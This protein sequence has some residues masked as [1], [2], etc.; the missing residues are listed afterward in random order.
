LHLGL[1]KLEPA[2]ICLQTIVLT[3]DYDVGEHSRSGGSQGPASQRVQWQAGTCT[4]AQ[5]C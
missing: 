2:L 5:Q 3:T 1:A 4:L